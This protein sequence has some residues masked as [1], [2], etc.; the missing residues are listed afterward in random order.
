[1]LFLLV[2]GFAGPALAR[3]PDRMARSYS[4]EA[5]L[6]L[7]PNP[8]EMDA[9]EENMVPEAPPKYRPLELKNRKFETPPPSLVKNI[10]GI[11]MSDELIARLD[12]MARGSIGSFRVET[13]FYYREFVYYATQKDS[14]NARPY[15]SSGLSEADELALRKA[16]ADTAKA[17]MIWKGIPNFLASR[18]ETKGIAAVY[19]QATNLTKFNVK[20]QPTAENAHPWDYSFGIDPFAAGTVS[21]WGTASNDRWK[22]NVSQNLKN[23][24]DMGMSVNRTLKFKY[25]G[26]VGTSASYA[27]IPAVLVLGAGHTFAH[28][29]IGLGLETDI[30]VKT[31]N[32]LRY[33]FYKA[34]LSYGF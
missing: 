14:R 7:T 13:G 6:S 11:M 28:P 1:M 8:D 19:N 5:S 4:R 23:I 29:A 31:E 9:P 2:A 26:E 12:N 21:A 32:T 3:G 20:G 25:F 16:M 30:P 27:L 34:T 24:H 22:I 33:V 17:Y 15:G 18:P 10:S